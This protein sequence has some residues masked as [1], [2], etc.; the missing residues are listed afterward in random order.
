MIGTLHEGA[1]AGVRLAWVEA[2]TGPTVV[3]LHGFP[4]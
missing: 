3:L 2:G 1:P 4:D